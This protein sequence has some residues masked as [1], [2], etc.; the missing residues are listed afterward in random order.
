[1]ATL[2]PDGI[3]VHRLVMRLPPT[4]MNITTCSGITQGLT[5]TS[6]LTASGQPKIGLLWLRT[7]Q[8]RGK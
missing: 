2:A 5:A 1:M 3:V 7:H 6:M 8:E 4:E